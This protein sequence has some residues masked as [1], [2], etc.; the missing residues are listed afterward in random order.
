MVKKAVTGIAKLLADGAPTVESPQQLIFLDDSHIPLLRPASSLVWR[1]VPTLDLCTSTHLQSQGLHFVRPDLHSCLEHASTGDAFQECFGLS[2]LSDL[3]M[4]RRIRVAED[5][6]ADDD[7]VDIDLSPASGLLKAHIHSIE[8]A[9]GL[10]A[11]LVDQDVYEQPLP[12][13][14]E[15]Q[16]VLQS[17]DLLCCPELSTGLYWTPQERHSPPSIAQSATAMLLAGTD[18]LAYVCAEFQPNGEALQLLVDWPDDLADADA[19]EQLAQ[20][21]NL[22]TGSKCPACSGHQRCT[23]GDAAAV[24]I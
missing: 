20:Q 24:C 15:L 18:E 7:H 8:F 6:D 17:V 1:D 21:L 14:R 2:R 13:V 4:E 16:R 9:Q 11:I 12:A 22:V 19:L 5:G 3:V 10:H 23:G